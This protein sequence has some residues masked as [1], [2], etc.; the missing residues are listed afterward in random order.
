ME[1]RSAC[2]EPRSPSNMWIVAW[3]Y[4][5]RASFLTKLWTEPSSVRTLNEPLASPTVHSIEQLVA[6]ALAATSCWIEIQMAIAKIHASLTISQNRQYGIV[7]E[8]PSGSPNDS[9]SVHVRSRNSIA[10]RTVRHRETSKRSTGSSEPLMFEGL[11]VLIECG[12]RSGEGDIEH[13]AGVSSTASRSCML[14]SSVSNDDDRLRFRELRSDS[15]S[16]LV[17]VVL[18]DEEPFGVVSIE[19]AFM[20]W[21]G[22]HPR[23]YSTALHC[24]IM[25]ARVLRDCRASFS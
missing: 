25:S 22:W 3:R 1:A 11:S 18:G 4:C 24:C 20:P 12:S 8:C 7:V 6:I 14:F 2:A 16:C 10:E 15:A 21:S 23:R 19:L 17:F 13:G 5:H 9:G